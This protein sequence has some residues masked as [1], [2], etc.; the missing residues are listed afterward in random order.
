MYRLR[1]E[2]SHFLLP[3]NAGIKVSDGTEEQRL[4]WNNHTFSSTRIGSGLDGLTSRIFT[5][6]R[7][8]VNGFIWYDVTKLNEDF[9]DRNVVG[10]G[11]GFAPWGTFGSLPCLKT[12]QGWKGHSFFPFNILYHFF[13]CFIFFL[14]K[15]NTKWSGVSGMTDTSPRTDNPYGTRNSCPFKSRLHR[16]RISAIL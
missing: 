13:F 15:N 3:I 14:I 5:M 4:I 2:K 1:L 16:S 10:L 11:T 8:L 12:V 7:N 6:T 9:R